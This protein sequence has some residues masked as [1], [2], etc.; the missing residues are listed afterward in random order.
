MKRYLFLI[1]IITWGGQIS[2]AQIDRTSIAEFT[3][4]EEMPRFPGCEKIED[5]KKQSKCADKKMME[6]F[7][8]HLKYPKEEE[9]IIPCGLIVVSVLIQS[10]GQVVNPVIRKDGGDSSCA[11]MVLDA[12]KKMPT[13]IPGKHR[14]QAVN[15][16]VN[17]PIR[18]KP[19]Y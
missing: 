17:I 12:I 9:G 7:F 18:V 4:V 15:V 13:W 8:K 3:I 10:D 2:F 1:L 16:R 19:S 6:F 11:E 5:E 14:G